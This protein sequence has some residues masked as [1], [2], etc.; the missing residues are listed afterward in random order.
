ME[1]PFKGTIEAARRNAALSDS[2]RDQPIRF[3]RRE[4]E[5][6]Y[7]TPPWLIE[8]IKARAKKE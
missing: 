2:D 3:V 6:I 7:Y 1:S 5:A 8:R 4:A